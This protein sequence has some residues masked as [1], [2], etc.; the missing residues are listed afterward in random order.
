MELCRKEQL[1]AKDMDKFV[2]LISVVMDIN[3][4]DSDGNAP[5][6]LLCKHRSGEGLLKDIETLLTERKDVNVKYKDSTWLDI[7]DQR[8]DLTSNEV[9][10]IQRI[11]IKYP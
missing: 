6:M 7:L 4:T 10:K 8:T 11:V 2:G 5:L 1:E 3:C 9:C